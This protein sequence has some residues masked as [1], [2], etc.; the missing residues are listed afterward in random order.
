MNTRVPLAA[1]AGAAVFTSAPAV[2]GAGPLTLA[3][4]A[5]VGAA[6]GAAALYDL[7]GRRIPNRLVLPASAACLAL[8]LGSGTSLFVLL[9]GLAIVVSLLMV[10]L[11][12]PRALGM[13]DVKLALLIVVG[14]DGDAARAF[15]V[16]LAFAALAAAV[17]L[18]RHGRR[19][20]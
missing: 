6:L 8:T 4:L 18:V 10:S 1:V 11:R 13:G 2:A 14:L 9:V 17:L 15:A 12:S 19:A 20:W 5:L 3:R 7:G 16:G